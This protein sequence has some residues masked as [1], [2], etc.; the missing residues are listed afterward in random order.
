MEKKDQLQNHKISD[1]E[2]EDIAGGQC[3]ISDT[4]YRPGSSSPKLSTALYHGEDISTSDLVGRNRGTAG[5]VSTKTAA[6]KKKIVLNG[7]NSTS[8]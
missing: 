3:S 1:D 5:Y 7:D 8:L 4:V 2:L 6:R